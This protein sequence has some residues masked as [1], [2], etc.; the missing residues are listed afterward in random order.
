[1]PPPPTG[2]LT[3]SV[4]QVADAQRANEFPRMSI[5]SA[6]MTFRRHGLAIAVVLLAAIAASFFPP[7]DRNPNYR[8]RH[9]LKAGWRIARGESA[10]NVL[11]RAYPGYDVGT[12]LALAVVMRLTIPAETLAAGPP[13]SAPPLYDWLHR[14]A[15]AAAVATLFAALMRLATPFVAIGIAALLLLSPNWRL[16]AYSSD[17]Y[18]FPMIALAATLMGVALFNAKSRVAWPGLIACAVAVALASLFRNVS[19][20]CICLML[21]FA[22]FPQ[23]FYRTDARQIIRRRA[24]AFFLLALVLAKIPGVFLNSSGHVFWHPLHCG[25]AEFGGH[26]D[27]QARLYPWFVPAADLPTDAVAID[28]WTDDRSFRRARHVIP[29][30]KTCSAEYDAIMREDYFDVW[31]RYPAGML[32]TYAMRLANVVT[33]N[34]MHAYTTASRIVPTS[35][36]RFLLIGSLALIIAAWRLRVP[37]RAWIFAI[38]LSPMLIPPIIAHSGYIMYNAPARLP[39]YIFALWTL[40]H[41]WR[42]WRLTS[43]QPAPGH[44]NAPDPTYAEAPD[45]V[46][47]AR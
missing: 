15:F 2:S 13:G 8:M 24:L 39:L 17:V 33:P 7:A 18:T 6:T 30:I 26:E 38:A 45:T 27:A 23:T 3:P 1:M 41:A 20:L 42:Q 22:I 9:T 12:P 46:A 25:L 4:S 36:D 31:R 11:S 43:K 21:A 28:D 35:A 19:I 10:A 5:P 14:A 37:T 34:P 32:Q 47:P 40:D 16:I 29:N 44:S